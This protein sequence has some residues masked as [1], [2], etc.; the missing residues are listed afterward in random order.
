M[1]CAHGSCLTP[2]T[3]SHAEAFLSFAFVV[4][5]YSCGVNAFIAAV[6]K[7]LSPVLDDGLPDLVR[8]FCFVHLRRLFCDFLR[9]IIYNHHLLVCRRVLTF[10]LFLH[11][12]VQDYHLYFLLGFFEIDAF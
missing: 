2:C 10:E 7:Y 3:L 8:H 4:A 1:S 12:I 9:A 5:A 11:S 6:G